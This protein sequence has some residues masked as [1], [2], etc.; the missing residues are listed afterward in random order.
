MSFST[1]NT[2]EHHSTQVASQTTMICCLS[3]PFDDS[4]IDFEF[5]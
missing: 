5:I 3:V 4:T 2:L 1:D